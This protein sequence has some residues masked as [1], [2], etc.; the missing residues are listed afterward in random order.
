ML[1]QNTVIGIIGSGNVG[2][3]LGEK[4]AK[5][6]Y[7]VL[8]SSRHPEELTDLVKSAGNGAEAVSVEEAAKR[9]EIIVLAVPFMAEATVS[10]QIQPFVKGKIV[11]LC[12]NAY[13]GRDGAIAEEA[14][15]VGVAYY[16]QQHYY[17]EV[18]L[19][20]AFSS[21]PIATVARATASNPVKIPYAADNDRAKAIAE[22]LIRAA[23]GTAEYVGKIADSRQ[24]DY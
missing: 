19:I 4:W 23:N 12:D 10:K 24:L 17:P 2:G 3:T 5:A 16:A 20:R 14:K 21:L 11:L 15:R 8:F 1:Q 18:A 22:E 7:K 9:G 6:G 13:P